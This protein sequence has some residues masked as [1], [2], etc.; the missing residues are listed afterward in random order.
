M[1]LCLVKAC[2]CASVLHIALLHVSIRTI[3]CMRTHT[4]IHTETHTCTHIHTQAAGTRRAGAGGPVD[5]RVRGPGAPAAGTPAAAAGA[6]FLIV[7]H[8]ISCPLCLVITY[9]YSCQ[10]YTV[11][12]CHVREG[13]CI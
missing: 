3:A 1:R 11:F 8:V 5:P 12:M 2:E 7:V 6:V 9:G 10:S 13:P 4:H